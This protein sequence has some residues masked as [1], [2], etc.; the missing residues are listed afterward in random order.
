MTK[1][2]TKQLNRIY[3]YFADQS[4]L[5]AEKGGTSLLLANH[6]LLLMQGVL[7]ALSGN[8]MDEEWVESGLQVLELLDILLPQEG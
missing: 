4:V 7:N 1:L 2:T 3:R 5:N 6:Y 8:E